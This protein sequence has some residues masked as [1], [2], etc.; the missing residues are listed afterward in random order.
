MKLNFKILYRLFL[1]TT[2]S[3]TVLNCGGGDANTIR[4]V[5]NGGQTYELAL[6]NNRCNAG[7]PSG[8]GLYNLPVVCSAGFS[9]TTGL[10]DTIVV[11][12]TDA[13]AVQDA[14][15]TYI[16]ISPSLL[17]MNFTLDG[18]QFA[19]SSGG[20]IFSQISNLAG[21]KTCFEFEMDTAQAHVEGNFCGTNAV[22]F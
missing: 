5:I 11:T 9:N 10:A 12:I 8:T 20:A 22:G 16:P 1:I 21:G 2:L 15:K 14:L 13:R 6:K 7:D 17:L 18:T 19:I 4:I 3:M